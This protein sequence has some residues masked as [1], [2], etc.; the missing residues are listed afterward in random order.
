[1]FNISFYIKHLF[2]VYLNVL[3]AADQWLM[4]RLSLLCWTSSGCSQ[5]SSWQA[6]WG[7]WVNR[8]CSG[9]LRDRPV[10]P[11]PGI[12]KKQCSPHLESTGSS[13]PPPGSSQCWWCQTWRR[14][15]SSISGRNRRCKSFLHVLDWK[16]LILAVF[17]VTPKLLIVYLNNQT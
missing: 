11:T 14:H 1:M 13:R 5:S 2:C 3:G 16:K 9:S 6:G 17:K 15:L 4:L 7:K 8:C 10:F 12:H